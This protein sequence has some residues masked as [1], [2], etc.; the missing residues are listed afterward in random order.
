MRD[1]FEP[2]QQGSGR[3]QRDKIERTNPAGVSVA[4][5]DQVVDCVGDLPDRRDRKGR[6]VPQRKSDRDE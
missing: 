6:H 3:E 5:V 2:D 4:D 1:E